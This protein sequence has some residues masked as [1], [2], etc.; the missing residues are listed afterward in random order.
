[1]N[2][3]ARS[4]M[5]IAQGAV[6]AFTNFPAAIACAAAFTAVTMTYATTRWF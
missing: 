6:K 4:I 5:Q 3:F 1:M 2:S